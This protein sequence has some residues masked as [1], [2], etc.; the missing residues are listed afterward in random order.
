MGGGGDLL[1]YA[2]SRPVCHFSAKKRV[3]IYGGFAGTETSIIE[4]AFVTNVA[5]LSGN[6]GA[7]GDST[8]N[9]LHVVSGFANA[10][11]AI[12]DGFTVT[13]GNA[14]LQ[15]HWRGGG[16]KISGSPTLANLIIFRNSCGY[17]FVSETSTVTKPGKG[18]VCTTWAGP[19]RWTTYN[20][21]V[22]PPGGRIR[23]AAGCSARMTMFK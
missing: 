11:T 17:R 10:A 3:A 19:L 18:A 20:S 12:L 5:I 6:I 4:R 15:T 2:G 8:D 13:A 7:P 22:T 21:E 23:V 9:S 1:P 14:N 16:I